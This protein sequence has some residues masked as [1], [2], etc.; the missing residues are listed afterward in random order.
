MRGGSRSQQYQE[1]KSNGQNSIKEESNPKSKQR[2]ANTRAQASQACPWRSKGLRRKYFKESA[3]RKHFEEC[4]SRG[5]NIVNNQRPTSSRNPLAN[6]PGEKCL[7]DVKECKD[8]N[9]SENFF[10]PLMSYSLVR[11]VL[12]SLFCLSSDLLLSLSS[13]ILINS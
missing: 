9:K 5:A 6:E 2:I 13:G 7:L 11:H 1:A 4:I 12:K 10:F 8:E 3:T